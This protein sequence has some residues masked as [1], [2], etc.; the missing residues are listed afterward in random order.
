MALIFVLH[1]C[2]DASKGQGVDKF[3]QYQPW[4]ILP[5]SGVASK[6]HGHAMYISGNKFI[7]SMYVTNIDQVFSFAS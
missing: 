7:L 3:P 4:Y 6:S 2:I 5:E 1:F